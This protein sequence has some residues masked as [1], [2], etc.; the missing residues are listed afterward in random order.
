[1][2]NYY[3]FGVKI[4][5]HT[6]YMYVSHLH[7]NGLITTVESMVASAFMYIQSQITRRLYFLDY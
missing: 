2:L 1:M 6:I 4:G 7:R 5:E 3:W